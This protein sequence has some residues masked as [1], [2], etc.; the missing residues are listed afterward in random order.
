MLCKLYFQTPKLN[1]SEEIAQN[2]ERDLGIS[3]EFW[4]RLQK[5][6]DLAV[7]TS[8]NTSL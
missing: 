7:K 5:E 8:I 3:A 6:Y 2:I 4:M 1:I